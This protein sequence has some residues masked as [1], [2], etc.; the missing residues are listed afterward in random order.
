MC[1]INLKCIV[2]DSLGR[3]HQGIK[4]RRRYHDARAETNFNYDETLLEFVVSGRMVA[5]GSA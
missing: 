3:L 1:A 4:L 5:T 2:K